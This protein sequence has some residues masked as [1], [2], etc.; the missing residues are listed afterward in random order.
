M[1][2]TIPGGA[3]LN[4][5]AW[6]DAEGRRLSLAQTAAAEKLA[7][8][9]AAERDDMERQTRERE[10]LRDPTTRALLAAGLG[11]APPVK[12]ELFAQQLPVE[13]ETAPVELEPESPVKGRK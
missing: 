12:T 6:V 1:A 9:R 3:Y 10:A 8:Q 4:N 11:Q 5:G 7:A 13:L 2:E